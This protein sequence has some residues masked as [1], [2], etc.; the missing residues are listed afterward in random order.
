[1]RAARQRSG[2]GAAVG[3]YH[4]ISRVVNRAFVLKKE[5]KEQLVK[6]MRRYELFCGVR[7]VTY[8]V[9]SNHFHIL[10]EVP[11]RPAAKE[12]PSDAQLVALVG[13]AQVSY[14]RATL[15]QD[16]ES[17]RQRGQD[18]AAEELKERFFGRMW[19]VS[20]FMRLLKQR[21]TQWYNKRHGRTGTLWED[22]FKSVL[23]EGAGPALSTMALYIDL[24]AV[25]AG[26]VKDPQ[27]YR[28]CGYAEAMGGKKEARR[29]L[30]VVVSAVNGRAVVAQRVMAEYRM[31]LFGRG[32][33]GEEAVGEDGRPVRLG[34]S[35]KR[36]EEVMARKGRLS[37]WESLRC[38]VR[39]LSDGVVLGGREFVESYFTRNRERFGKKRQEGARPM[40][41]VTLPGLF[42]MRD[43]QKAP[44]G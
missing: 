41:Y 13:K 12:L 44:I 34:V 16:L 33:Q 32:D 22:R 23:V 29:G 38:R 30:S 7:V 19:D 24:N 21:F 20:W 6:W 1:M 27:Q 43:L 9:M 4:C 26:V 17:F 18:Q 15:E 14:G 40:R 2:P 37:R 25:R 8:C 35:A 42:T 28:W 11:R 5:E 39:Y 31:L 10:V 36:V 3:Y